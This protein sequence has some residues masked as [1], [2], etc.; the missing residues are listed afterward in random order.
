MLNLF[1]VA[2]YGAA[3]QNLVYLPK[4]IDMIYAKGVTHPYV[5]PKFSAGIASGDPTLTSVILWSRI[6]NFNGNVDILISTNDKFTRPIKH[7]TTTDYSHDYVVKI[8]ATNL[9]PDTKYFY[10]FSID[11]NN[12]KLESPVGITKTLPKNTKHLKVAVASCADYPNGFFTSYRVMV[13]LQADIVVFLGDYIYEYANKVY[14]DGTAMN[15]IPNP[16]Q[17]IITLEDYR[18]RHLQYKQDKD[19][20]YM[21]QNIPMIAVWDGIFTY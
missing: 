12:T 16:D 19:L 11:Y 3:L 6:S 9:S 5:V 20:Q 2:V 18:K 17:A 1:L 4:Y 14:G 13:I 15:R 8:D 7:T 21:H 10:K